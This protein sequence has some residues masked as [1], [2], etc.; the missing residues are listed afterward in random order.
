MNGWCQRCLLY[1]DSEQ[2]CRP[3][4]VPARPSATEHA[5]QLAAARDAVIEAAVRYVETEEGDPRAWPGGPD[6]WMA[7][8]DDAYDA[9]KEARDRLLALNPRSQS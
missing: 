7:A 9:L 5:Q 4:P 6:D 2:P 1:H 8:N 3:F